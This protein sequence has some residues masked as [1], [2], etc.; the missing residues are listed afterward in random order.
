MR[1][2]AI[3]SGRFDPPNAGHFMTIEKL[4]CEYAGVAV[5]VLTT[6]REA[7]SAEEAM[8]IFDWHFK[9]VLPT[10]AQNKVETVLFPE[11][12]GLI[13]KDDLQKLMVAMEFNKHNAVYV[14]GN[15]PVLNHIQDLDI[16]PVRF[17]PRVHV[18]EVTDEYLFESTRVRKKMNC[19]ETLEDQ[20]G[21]DFGPR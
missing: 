20:Y 7:C 18:N 16:L 9:A 17:M 15:L 3:F 6:N 1:Q 11:H 12:F 21:I 4:C 14:T 5:I 2:W 10:I 8:A 19:G 13:S